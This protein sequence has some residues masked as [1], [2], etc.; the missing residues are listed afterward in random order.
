MLITYDD[1]IN[2]QNCAQKICDHSAYLHN[3]LNYYKK[4]YLF[5]DPHYKN[6]CQIRERRK[7]T[8]VKK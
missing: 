2:K 5:V 7:R 6:R 4:N 1:Y 3:I 8:Q